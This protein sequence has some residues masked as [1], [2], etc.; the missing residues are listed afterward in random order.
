MRSISEDNK[1]TSKTLYIIGNG[2][3]LAHE[4][5][6]SY[7]DYKS[8][9]SD[10]ENCENGGTESY[11]IRPKERECVVEKGLKP[12]TFFGELSGDWSN[13]EE[14]LGAYEVETIRQYIECDYKVKD[15]RV[16][17]DLKSSRLKYFFANT[18]NALRTLFKKW[19]DN[20]DI[21]VK[22]NNKQYP[23]KKDSILLTFN[24][25]ETL[26]SLYGI[27]IFRICYIHGKRKRDEQYVFGHNRHEIPIKIQKHLDYIGN[28]DIKKEVIDIMND[29]VK[30]YDRCLNWLNH[31]LENEKIN[32]VVVYGHSLGGVDFEYF[33]MIVN[34]IGNIVPWTVDYYYEDEID[35]IYN[36]KKN[37][38]LT[39]VYVR[40]VNIEDG[41]LKVND[42]ESIK[43]YN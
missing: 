6:S 23:F 27:E 7:A 11:I 16:E 25:T 21:N 32:E 26:E 5:K 31:F 13:I 41:Y 9:Y 12:E 2:F 4:I 43:T 40:C 8:F 35:R 22:P 28:I 10:K 17:D 19:V 29:F 37:L 15:F 14:A 39:N 18:I 20:I 34:K 1:S 3:D 24:Y 33:K 36:V 30:P 38:N 42:I